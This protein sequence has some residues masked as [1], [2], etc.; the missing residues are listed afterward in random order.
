VDGGQ[1]VGSAHVD[2]I[3]RASLWSGT[4]NSWVDLHLAGMAS[5]FAYDVG[6]GQQ[7]G[8]AAVDVD[9]IH[10]S[11]WN[12]DAGSWVDLHPTG[13]V[14]SIATGVDG[15]EQVGYAYYPVGEDLLPRASLWSGTAASW[16]DL[17]PAG[18]TESRAR[19]ADGGYQVGYAA[20][21]VD[22]IHASLWNGDAGSWVDLHP[23]GAI[24]SNATGV[25]GGQQVGY[26]KVSGRFHAGLWEGTADS[27]V[28]LH[29]AG[30]NTSSEALGVHGGQQVGFV[31]NNDPYRAALW[32]GSAA[33]YVDLHAFLP[34]QFQSSMANGIWHDDTYTYVVGYG[35]NSRRDRNE[36]LMWR[37]DYSPTDVGTMHVHQMSVGRESQGPWYYGSCSVYVYD[38][39]EEPVQSA[40][41][42][43]IVTGPTTGTVSG[44]TDDHGRVL[45]KSPKTRDPVGD[46]CFTVTGIVHAGYIY[47][48][49]GNHM[50]MPVCESRSAP[51]PGGGSDH[52]HFLA[53]TNR[54]ARAGNMVQEIAFRVETAGHVMLDIFDITGAQVATLID[55]WRSA[56]THS[57][58]FDVSRQGSGVYFARLRVGEEID[59]KRLVVVH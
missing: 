49:S 24:L 10:A 7:V 38:H 15:A 34:K 32:S 46:W 41:V 21:D 22:V 28:D 54:T 19:E 27:W 59:T 4:A 11:L 50:D 55:E 17:H 12:G 33:S 35:Y 5:S 56:G 1:Q 43:A 6:G 47:D 42:E 3:E 14:Q 48:P 51:G 36:A 45:L 57:A 20:V 37:A 30:E 26:A 8:Y 23:A 58:V 31:F 2:G 39:E 44:R 13:A 18:T 52:V 9:V 16:V 29:P 40:E 53:G 25:S